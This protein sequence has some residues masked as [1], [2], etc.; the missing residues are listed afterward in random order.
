MQISTETQ[1]PLDDFAPRVGFAWTPL[2]GNL[3]D[4]FVVRG[5]AGIF[6]NQISGAVL[7]MDGLVD[8]PYALTPATSPLDSL[9]TPACVVPNDSWASGYSRLAASIREFR[10]QRDVELERHSVDVRNTLP[11]Q[12]PMSGI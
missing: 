7:T 6:Y 9:A 11:F 10:D 2:S 4:R 5:G 3:G 8:P 12:P 1:A